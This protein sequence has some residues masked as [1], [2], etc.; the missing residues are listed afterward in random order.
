MLIETD[1]G[2]ILCDPW[3]EPAF[4]GSWFPFPRNDQLSDELRER[5]DNADF[6]YVSHLHGDHHDKA[7]LDQHLRRDIPILLPGFPTREQRRTLAE[8]GFS[9][10]VQTV[11]TEELEIAPGLKVAIHIES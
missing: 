10:F 9:N 6:L 1:A 2:S 11:D 3:F 4:F 8:H 7:W 5:I